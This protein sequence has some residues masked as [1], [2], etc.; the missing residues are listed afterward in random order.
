MNHTGLTREEQKLYERLAAIKLANKRSSKDGEVTISEDFL[1][2][3]NT[4]VKLFSISARLLTL[5]RRVRDSTLREAINFFF[6]VSLLQNCCPTPRYLIQP[7]QQ[8]NMAES[9]EPWRAA[10]HAEWATMSDEGVEAQ[11]WTGSMAVISSL[12][13]DPPNSWSHQ[14]Q[15]LASVQYAPHI[16][17]THA[18]ELQQGSVDAQQ[19]HGPPPLLPGPQTP[20]QHLSSPPDCLYD[21]RLPRQSQLP[22]PR[23]FIHDEL[24]HDYGHFQSCYIC[25]QQYPRHQSAAGVTLDHGDQFIPQ[26]PVHEPYSLV[27]GYR[28]PMP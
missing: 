16:G 28:H 13:L 23:P 26:H 25:P 9:T 17:C 18:A 7:I 2:D 8:H 6:L 12:Y 19:V 14:P 3:V 4:K 10:G 24:L 20:L 15:Q 11:A 21:Q 27:S 22:D 5:T 1:P